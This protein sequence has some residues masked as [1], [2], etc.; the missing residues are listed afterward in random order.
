MSET[1]SSNSLIRRLKQTLLR[2]R[3]VF[4]VAGLFATVAVVLAMSVVL[5]L[6]A[7]VIILPVAAKITLLAVSGILGL[8]IFIKFAAGRL[9]SGTVEQV[10][11]TL[12]GAYPRLK[13]RLIA[14][15]QFSRMKN[16][17]GY[18]PCR[19]LPGHHRR[20]CGRLAGAITRPVQPFV[21]CLFQHHDSNSPAARIYPGAVSGH[22]RVGQVSR[23]RIRRGGC[24]RPAA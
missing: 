7:A 24:R 15:I 10:A 3:L 9:L 8:A 23:Y 13:G 18:S 5:S 6:L 2:Q 12:E 1:T 21:P 11:V 19:T 14:A 17:P 4:F 16:N 22:G 20:Y